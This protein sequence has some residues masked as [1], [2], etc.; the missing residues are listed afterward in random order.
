[1]QNYHNFAK[2]EYYMDNNVRNVTEGLLE[3]LKLAQICAKV[4]SFVYC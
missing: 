2:H 3:N 4:H 1:M